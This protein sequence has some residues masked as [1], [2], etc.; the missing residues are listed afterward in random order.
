MCE[1]CHS[2]LNFRFVVVQAL[3]LSTTS[4]ST[5]ATGNVSSNPTFLVYIVAFAIVTRHIFEHGMVADVIALALGS[6]H[7]MIVKR[8]GSVWSSGVNADGRSDSFLQVIPRGGKAIAAGIGYSAVLKEDG[9]IWATGENP[10][11]QRQPCASDEPVTK[12]CT[13][14]FVRTIPG[15]TAI[16]AGG[17]HSIVLTKEGRVWATGWNKYGQLG[18]ESTTDRTTFSLVFCNGAV[19]VAAGDVHSVVLAKDK[20]LWT[21]GRNYNGQLGDGSKQDHNSFKAVLAG[22]VRVAAGG[23]HTMVVKHDG[24]VWTT[25]WNVY[26]Q[27]GDGTT[28]DRMKYQKVMKKEAETIAAGSR[29]SMILKKDGSVWA[30]GYNVYGQLGD[31]SS[32]NKKIFKQVMAS[33]ATTV[34]AGIYIYVTSL[35]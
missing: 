14:T 29:H 12:R 34:A 13:F 26:G 27:L 11:G 33:G 7:T 19:G 20:T 22:A 18:D 21:V 28:I 1:L 3:G 4:N 31:G 23:Y 6:F 5:A 25:G 10:E 9:S 32:L 16:A 24:S 2:R 35:I 15:A 30:T 17:Y 8:D